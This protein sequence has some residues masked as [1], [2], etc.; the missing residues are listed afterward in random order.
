MQTYYTVSEVTT[1]MGTYT[2]CV[3]RWIK[4][5]LLKA[6]KQP[7][8]SYKIRRK[9]IIKFIEE[10]PDYDLKNRNCTTVEDFEGRDKYGWFV[11]KHRN[12]KPGQPTYRI[13]GA[14]DVVIDWRD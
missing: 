7:N 8:G 12:G 9:D 14:L 11:W 5:G 6:T 13:F 4:R 1:V 10:N 2:R 3:H